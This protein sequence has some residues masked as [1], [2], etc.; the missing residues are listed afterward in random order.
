M[1]GPDRN[2]VSTVYA[3]D[4]DNDSVIQGLDRDNVSVIY[5]KDW[6]NDSSI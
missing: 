4:W 1:Y 6:D 2:N 5:G 3:L